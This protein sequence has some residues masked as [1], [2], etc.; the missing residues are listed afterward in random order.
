MI[1]SISDVRRHFLSGKNQEQILK[2]F[3][4]QQKYKKMDILIVVVPITMRPPLCN[5]STIEMENP[6]QTEGYVQPSQTVTYRLD[7][8][9]RL[10][11]RRVTL[12]VCELNVYVVGR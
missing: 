6:D 9:W 8:F 1:T 7:S 2:I 3:I 10:S 4:V 5:G 11:T 12:M